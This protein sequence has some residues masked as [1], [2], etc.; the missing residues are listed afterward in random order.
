MARVTNE[1]DNAARRRDILDAAQRLVF[2]KGYEPMTIQD[3]LDALGM[4]KG[5]FYHYFDS[6]AAVLE[7]LIARMRDD[8]MSVLKPL[9]DDPALPALDKIRRFFAAS[10]RWKTDRRDEL[11]PLVRTL[12]SD[13]N[14]VLRQKLS[15]Q[16][17]AESALLLGDVIR[18]GIR[19]DAL[20]T[21]F[22]DQAGEIAMHVLVNLSE[23][24][25]TEILKPSLNPADIPLI[26]ARVTAYTDALERVLGAPAGSLPII[27]SET[28]R[29]W[30]APSAPA[31]RPR[32]AA[33]SV[34]PREVNS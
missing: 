17:A 29:A 31:R 26:E 33:G 10:G 32:A 34:R 2:S 16:T 8:A 28:L 27:D 25:A 7:A 5:A 23:M 20:S 4:S 18:Q 22:P 11:L 9:L 12:Y 14:F 13:N 3:I 19:E 24:L 30:F 15:A 6:K 1:Q 21:P